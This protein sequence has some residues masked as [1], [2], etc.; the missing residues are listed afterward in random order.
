VN[1]R[2]ARFQLMVTILGAALLLGVGML[3]L[4]PFDSQ[5]GGFWFLGAATA[6]TA[7]RVGYQIV[8]NWGRRM[9]LEEET[10][11]RLRRFRHYG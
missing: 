1:P 5:L 3:F 11:A 7:G 4:I 6:W 9:Q 8:D 2:F 10:K